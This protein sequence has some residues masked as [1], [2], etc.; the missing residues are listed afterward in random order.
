M[1][2][3]TSKTCSKCK[4]LKDLS[5]F[6]NL[7]CSPDGYRYDCK[8]CRKIYRENNKEEIKIKQHEFYENN[9]NELLI[10]NKE[11]RENNS[12]IINNQRKEYRNRPEIK[13]HQRI[14]NKEYLSIR[15]IKT[16][17]KRLT[18]K[19]FQISEVI[20][21]KIHKILKGIPT[22]YHTMI[23]CDIDFL[24]K[25]L[26]FR[27]DGNMNWDN[28]GKIWQIDHILPINAFNFNN[29][30]NKYICFNWTNLQSLSCFENKSKSAKLQLHYYFNN[31]VNV[32]RFNT[33]YNQFNGYQILNE[34]LR[35]LRDNELR[36][37][38][39]PTDEG[40]KMPEM[41]NPQPSL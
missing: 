21:S 40:I 27:F 37:G 12:I 20:R 18:N 13:E 23:G 9:K 11:Y 19:N 39:N 14:K 30:I 28:F 8:S 3:I 31:I 10:K 32:N 24:K 26:E 41:D 22:S 38:K 16:K 15:S 29:E 17:E 25:W 35:W 7:K 6:G 5:N 36:Y 1:T 33:K 2:T 4:I 34:S